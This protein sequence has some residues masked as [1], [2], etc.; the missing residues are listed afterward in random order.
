[1]AFLRRDNQEMEI[2]LKILAEQNKK[3]KVELEEQEAEIAESEDT[4][5]AL[6]REIKKKDEQ[7]QILKREDQDPQVRDAERQVR[8]ELE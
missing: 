1:M 4:L 5:K 6:Q 2:A 7:I 8:A 3:F